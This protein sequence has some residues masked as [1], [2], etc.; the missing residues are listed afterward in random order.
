M[1]LVGLA[2]P[3]AQAQDERFDPAPV[4][5]ANALTLDDV[6]RSVVERHPLLAAAEQERAIASA[7]VLSAEGGFDPALRAR[8]TSIPLGPYPSDRVDT[9]A[10]L[11]TSIWGT[12]LFAGYRVSRGDFAVYDSKLVT[13]DFGE[14]RVGAQVPLWRDGPIDRRRAALQKA[15]LGTDVARLSVEQQRLEAVRL[16]SHRYWD[17]VAAGRRVAVARDMLG[18][19]VARDAGLA[20]R[21]ERGDIPAFERAENER[22]IHQRTAQVAST[23]RALQ[24]AT[25]ELSLFL[26]SADGA[27]MQPEPTRLPSAFPPAEIRV[28]ADTSAA[29]RQALV[30]RPELRRIELVTQQTRVDRDLANNQRKLGLDFFV[31]GAKDF[32]P[33]YDQKLLKPELEV[34]LLLD[35]PLLTRVQ[36]GRVQAAQAT[37]SRLDLQARFARDRLIAD[38]RDASSAVA[39]AEERIASVR[40]E[41][42]AS[43]QLVEM[44]RQRF[45]LGEG[46]LLLVNIREQ[47]LAEAQQREIDAL[48]DYFKAIASQRA[49]VA[50]PPR[51][52]P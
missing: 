31:S 33:A 27:P 9:V 1:A 3:A 28:P 8:V 10:E 19:A 26:R 50:A 47:G 43:R 40:R 48:A 52:G 11:P 29:E 6:V 20:V 30:R 4:Q 37:L 44:E 35:V 32:G 25:I 7:D 14:A 2:P 23:E 16:G 39:M 15:E 34:A 38:V 36:D 13:G 12:R 21:V 18:I 49:A 17:W 22:V 24:N 51:N 41:I 45:E 46:T 42:T 5:E